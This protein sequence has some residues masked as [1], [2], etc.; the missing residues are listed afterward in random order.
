MARRGAGVVRARALTVALAGALLLGGC[1]QLPGDYYATDVDVSRA[2]RVWSD[3]W[4][5]PSSPAVP[6]AGYGSNGLVDRTAGGR[7]TTYVGLRAIPA[8]RQEVAVARSFG[9]EL[10][11]VTCGEE[12]VRAVLTRGG[13]DLEKAAVARVD[14]EEDTTSRPYAVASVSV[15]AE[16]PHHLDEDWP[17]LGPAVP[18]EETCLAGGTGHSAPDLPDGKPRGPADDDVDVP[19][20][21]DDGLTADEQARLDAASADPWLAAQTGGGFDAPPKTPE[22]NRVRHSPSRSGTLTP[23]PAQPTAMVAAVVA[24]M[25]GWVLTYAACS[26][27]TGAV[28]TLRLDTDDGPVTARLE[29][30]PREEGTLTWEVAV[31]VIAGPDLSS[32]DQVP[33]LDG[34]T[35]LDSASAPKEPVVEGIPVGVPGEQQP[36]Q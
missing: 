11:G 18:T 5:A 14:A 32:F 26:R 22:G 10:V 23:G 20:W 13:T 7:S 6:R 35:C 34:S 31:P 28:A 2:E 27:A 12:Q 4:V 3:P 29:A 36:M 30:V 24:D 15:T 25:D 17:D 16:V 33:A 9:W 1:S 8:V 19:E 21:S